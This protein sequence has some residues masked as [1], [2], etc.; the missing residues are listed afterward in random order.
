M[1]FGPEATEIAS[2]ISIANKVLSILAGINNPENEILCLSSSVKS[3]HQALSTQNEEKSFKV[4][5]GSGEQLS[6]HLGIY[7]RWLQENRSGIYG[8]KESLQ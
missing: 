8:N 4:G 1:S 7:P 3:L 6:I 2:V 5:P